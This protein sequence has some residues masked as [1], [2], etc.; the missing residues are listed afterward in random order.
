[1]KNRPASARLRF[2]PWSGKEVIL[3]ESF[4]VMIL[5][6]HVLL[7]KLFKFCTG[8]QPVNNSVIVS[9]KQRRDSAIC[10][11]PQTPFH[12]GDDVTLSRVP[13]YTVRPRLL[14]ILNI[15]VCTR[16]SQALQVSLPPGR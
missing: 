12:S 16:P 9:Y 2:N 4:S 3:E 13:R 15:A 14:S 6:E 1:M 11:L 10:I 7:F 8:V 5:G